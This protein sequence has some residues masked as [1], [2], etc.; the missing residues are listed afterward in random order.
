MGFPEL[1]KVINREMDYWFKQDL[2]KSKQFE[3]MAYNLEQGNHKLAK[4]NSAKVTKLLLKDVTHGFAWVIPKQLVPLI[5]N[6]MVEPLGLAKQWTL[7][8]AGDRVL[9][10][11]L[12]QD[13]S[14]SN[15][16]NDKNWLINDRF[17]MD[18]YPKMICGWC[19]PRVLHFVAALRLTHP[20]VSIWIAKYDYSDAYRQVAHSAT[21]VAQTISTCKGFAY[22]YSCLTFGGS[23][24]P[25]IWC[26]FSEIITDLA[27]EIGQCAEWDLDTL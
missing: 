10:Y 15:K 25:P 5:P 13:L 19:L 17:D 18:A 11:R 23:P 8:K 2:S 3:E 20:G 7:N 24:T 26:N 4:A 22:I 27:N 1:K 16:V 14:H 21:T 9:K 12:T 6:A